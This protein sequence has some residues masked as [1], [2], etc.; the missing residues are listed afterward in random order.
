MAAFLRK[1]FANASRLSAD[2]LLATIVRRCLRPLAAPSD[3]FYETAIAAERIDSLSESLALWHP[4][5]CFISACRESATPVA[6]SAGG[7]PRR[8]CKSSS[9]EGKLWPH[10]PSRFRNVLYTE[11]NAAGIVRRSPHKQRRTFAT[12]PSAAVDAAVRA[13]V[14]AGSLLFAES[15]GQLDF[16]QHRH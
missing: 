6:W 4:V 14:L 2:A 3:C 11:C 1:R 13:I 16:D 9:P 8:S 10:D 7:A 12:R 5:P 15:E